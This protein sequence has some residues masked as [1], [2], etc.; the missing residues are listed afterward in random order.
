MNT[1][2]IDCARSVALLL[3]SHRIHVL[4][5]YLLNLWLKICHIS[6]ICHFYGFSLK[7]VAQNDVLDKLNL[8]WKFV[9]PISFALIG[10]EVL[11]SKL[12][13]QLVGYGIL[14]V[15]VGSTVSHPFKKKKIFF[16]PHLREKE[17]VAQQPIDCVVFAIEWEFT[18]NLIEFSTSQASLFHLF[19]LIHKVKLSIGCSY[20]EKYL[21]SS[22]NLIDSNQYFD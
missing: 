8:L 19:E 1:W 3:H 11:F 15:I 12:D 16:L 14:I 6:K 21:L 4:F 9:K 5:A 7:F 2:F 10:K 17:I 13:A 22:L 18:R 20:C